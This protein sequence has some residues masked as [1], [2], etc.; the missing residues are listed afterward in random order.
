MIRS[1]VLACATAEAFGMAASAGAARAAGATGTTTGFVLVVAGGLVE[2]T[3]LGALQATVIRTRL[4]VSRPTWIVATVV[5]AGLGWAA[6]S[7]PAALSGD[8]G[9]SPPALG[10]ILAGAVALGSAMGAVLGVAQAAVLR[11]AGVRHPWRWVTANATGWAV[12]MP[13][14]FT[15]ATTA[16]ASWPWP[17]VVGYGA[18]TGALA[19]AALGLVT[20]AFLPT[21]DGPPLRHRMVLWWLTTRRASAAEG[22]TAL[23]VKGARTGRHYRFPVMAASLEPGSL[24]VLPGHPER[25][26]WWRN[27]D[28]HSRVAV[29][30]HGAW[31]PAEARLV[32]RGSAPWLLAREAYEARWPRAKV[33]GAALVVVDLHD[34]PVG[35]AQDQGPAAVG[36]GAVGVGAHRS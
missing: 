24:V 30:D 34:L 21:L 5:V 12:A 36:P 19:G 7:A 33:G 15:G 35:P 11:R 3:A 1:W 23:E 26:T 16:G 9:G 27:V 28:R 4:G 31:A 25:K 29:L 32:L 8:S 18:I 20:G 13:V 2:G 10:W 22:W 17:V 14:I 6:A